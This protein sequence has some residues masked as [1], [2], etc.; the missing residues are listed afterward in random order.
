MTIIYLT[1]KP[2][3]IMFIDIIVPYLLMR[4]KQKCYRYKTKC[5]QI[6]SSLNSR[7]MSD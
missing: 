7:L 6:L 1:A 3:A 5:S 2:N 4:R